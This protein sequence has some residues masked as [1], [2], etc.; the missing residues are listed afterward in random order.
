MCL[1]D[2]GEVKSDWQ[3]E[4]KLNRS[5]LV[6]A[7]NG[8]LNLNVNLKNRKTRTFTRVKRQAFPSESKFII[9]RWKVS[10]RCNAEELY[11]ALNSIVLL[12]PSLGFK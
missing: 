1:P 10:L 4:V 5:T 6:V 9:L 3:L 11:I 12:Q 7:A 2:K 8:I